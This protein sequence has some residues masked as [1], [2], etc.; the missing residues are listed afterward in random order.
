MS[1]QAVQFAQASEAKTFDLRHRNT[2]NFNIS[3]YDNAVGAG[4]VYYQDHDLARSRAAYIKT[5]TLEAL[6]KHLLHFEENFTKRGGK[7]IWAAT[8][9]EALAAVDKIFKEKSARCV[10]KSKSMTTE[11]IHLNEYLEKQGLEVVE[12]DLGEY[13]VQL[14]GQKPYHIVTPAMHLSRKDVGEIFHQKLGIALTDDAQALTG[15]ARTLLREKYTTAEIGITGANFLVADVGGIAITENEGNARLSTTF[16]KTHIAIVGLEK[17]IPSYQDLGL[18]WPLLSTSGTGQRMTV[19]NT[20]LTG[21]RQ[22]GEPDGPEEMYVILLD[23]GRTKLLADPQKRQALNCIRCGA[24]LNACPV[25][26]N[27]GG[28]T[29][30]ATYSG[31]IGSVITPH[32]EGMKQFKHLSDASSLCGACG[33][34]C[35]VRIDIPNLLLLNRQEGVNKKL[36]SKVERIG[37]RLWRM[38][39]LKRRR[40]DSVGAGLKN[41]VIKRLFSKSWGKRRTLPPIA[42]QSFAQRWKAERGVK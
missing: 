10:V 3:K 30:E 34:V 16:P 19:Y 32:F 36:V 4:M 5:Q 6:D 21:P 26:K 42:K 38:A 33:S 37:F 28:H 39:M 14:A 31:P 23:N 40:M 13:I 12:T 8:A 35:P 15:I 17:I 25:Y 20:L 7:V 24:C 29:Y 2:I 1:R 22:E 11:E 27:I 18:F 9:Q 41:T